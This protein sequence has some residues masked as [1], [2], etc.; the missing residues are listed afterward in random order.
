MKFNLHSLSSYQK[1]FLKEFSAQLIEKVIRIIVGVFVIRELSKYLGVEQFGTFNFVESYFLIIMALSLFGLDVI[2]VRQLEGNKRYEKALGN[3]IFIL[4]FTSLLFI[5]ISIL[6]GRV[7]VSTDNYNNI[8]IVSLGLV[9]SPLIVFESYYISLNKIRITS[10]FKTISY[11]IKSILIIYFISEKYDFEYFIFLIISEYLLSGIFIFLFFI[12]EQNKISFKID[13]SLIK[14]ILGSSFYIFIYGIGALIFFRVDVFMIENFLSNYEMGIYTAA[15]K[16]LIFLYFIPNLIAQ[17][18]FPRIIKIFKSG[19]LELKPLKKMYQ[20][21]FISGLITFLFIVLFGDFIINF[22]FGNDFEESKII[23][24]VLSFNIIFI[25]IGSIY[26]KVIYSS[27][28]EKR[29]FLRVIISL[30]I[31]IILNILLIP[32]FQLLGVAISTIVSLFFLEII[33]D[34]FD[35]KLISLH[36][37]KLKSILNISK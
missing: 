27:N 24:K 1:L 5:A 36:V 28:M 13:L 19:K 12:K 25:S 15:F 26:T 33:Y 37:F 4:L 16:V 18:F 20:L 17:T 2:M 31:N 14:Q 35:K 23:L 21:T 22:L 34:F 9:F 7:F 32:Y 8:L 10:F 11:L 6:L 3:G 29:L 30:I